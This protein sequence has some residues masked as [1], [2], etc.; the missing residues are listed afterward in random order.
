MLEDVALEDG[1]TNSVRWSG[2][3]AEDAPRKYLERGDWI[4]L[5]RFGLF[6]W[7]VRQLNGF[8]CVVGQYGGVCLQGAYTSGSVTVRSG[9]Y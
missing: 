2:V 8:E 9:D 6:A 7:T 3:A 1:T 4:T 5:A